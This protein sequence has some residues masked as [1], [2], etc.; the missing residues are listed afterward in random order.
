MV[1]AWLT[2]L[3]L[4]QINRALL[5]ARLCIICVLASSLRCTAAVLTQNNRLRVA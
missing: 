2:E 3:Y 4:D 5:E 1:A